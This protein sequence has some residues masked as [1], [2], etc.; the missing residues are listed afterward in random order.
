M[1][2]LFGHDTVAGA[3][4]PLH[5]S[6]VVGVGLPPVP[7][8]RGSVTSERVSAFT[9]IVCVVLFDNVAVAVNCALAP[10]FGAVPLTAT[11]ETVAVVDVGVVGDDAV[12]VDESLP[13]AQARTASATAMDDASII[14]RIEPL[15]TDY[16][17]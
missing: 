15:R 3:I 6:D 10:T 14:R 17:C 7:P 11:E 12:E 1:P 9:V 2:P 16:V 5:V 13:H 8:L 4:A